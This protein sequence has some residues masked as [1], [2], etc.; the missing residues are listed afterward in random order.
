MIAYF[1]FSISTFSSF[2]I[3]DAMAPGDTIV[4]VGHPITPAY[5]GIYLIAYT[6]IRR[7]HRLAGKTIIIVIAGDEEEAEKGR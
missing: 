4:A 7:G 3:D 1:I 2:E 5:G 6:V